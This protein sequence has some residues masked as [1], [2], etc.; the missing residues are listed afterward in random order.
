MKALMSLWYIH[1]GTI[2]AKE[3][4]AAE[5]SVRNQ[6]CHKSTCP[7]EPQPQ[8]FPPAELTNVRYWTQ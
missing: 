1:M 4:I 5:D 6:S 7:C 2:A 3:M 8:I